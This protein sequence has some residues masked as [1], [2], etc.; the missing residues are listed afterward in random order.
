M[1]RS[2]ALSSSIRSMPVGCKENASVEFFTCAGME[3]VP[4]L[5]DRQTGRLT[6]LALLATSAPSPRCPPT[7]FPGQGNF[8]DTFEPSTTSKS[9]TNTR[10]ADESIVIFGKTKVAGRPNES[11]SRPPN[12]ETKRDRSCRSKPCGGVPWPC[13]APTH[14]AG[15][16]EA[17]R[18]VATSPRSPPGR[19]RP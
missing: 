12:G 19:D 16:G 13:R 7:R 3:P 11:I 18:D 17:N 1:A 9:H 2:S 6:D 4:Q 10:G 8:G 5:C 15:S 14:T